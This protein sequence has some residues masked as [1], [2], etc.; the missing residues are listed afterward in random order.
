MS[1][2]E[3]KVCNVFGLKT[4]QTFYILYNTQ[5]DA[6]SVLN[7]GVRGGTNLCLF[8]LVLSVQYPNQF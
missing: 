2:N 8:L 6:G 1:I 5:H 4:A 7:A 3:V